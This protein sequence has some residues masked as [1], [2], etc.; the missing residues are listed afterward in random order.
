MNECDEYGTMAL[1]WGWF[2]V[3]GRPSALYMHYNY[4]DD[5]MIMNFV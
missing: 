4:N 5:V 2:L 1:R 3:F